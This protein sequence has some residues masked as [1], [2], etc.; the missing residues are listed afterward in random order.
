MKSVLFVEEQMKQYRAPLYATLYQMLRKQNINLLVA[1]SA[2][3]GQYRWEQDCQDLPPEY[4]LRV[5]GYRCFGEKLLYQPLLR[6][7]LASDLIIVDQ[8]NRFLLNYF[9]LPLALLRIKKVA[10]WGMGANRQA[11]PG[12]LP[13]RFRRWTTS[14]VSWWFAYTAGTAEHV[15]NLGFP[16]KRITN[17]SNSTD[18]RRFRVLVTEIGESEKLRLRAELG[19]DREDPVAVFC[20]RL[21]PTKSLPFL[22]QAARLVKQRCPQFHLILIGA[23]PPEFGATAGID[24]VG[25]IHFTGAKFGRDKA[26][27]FSISDVL[28]MPGAVGLVIVDAFAAGLP[29]LTTDG[30]K[31]GPEI[32]YLE[33]GVNGLMTPADVKE[34]AMATSD[35]LSRREYLSHLRRGA[36]LSGDKYSI[37]TMAHNFSVGIATCLEGRTEHSANKGEETARTVVRGR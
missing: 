13:E 20:G 18:S 9:L 26:A 19:I 15:A 23:G 2:P 11:A 30:R 28:L 37:E 4:G 34:F 24:A 14:W 33:S 10:F 17:V 22:L 8:G 25:W 21:H 3:A 5:R 31:H 29:L 36:W 7:S 35:V 6:Q 27:L 12:S 16:V 1:Y 32:E